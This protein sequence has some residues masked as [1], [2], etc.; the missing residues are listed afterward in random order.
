MDWTGENCT[1]R[2]SLPDLVVLLLS[3]LGLILQPLTPH[4]FKRGLKV[5]HIFESFLVDITLAVGIGKVG[6]RPGYTIFPA[7]LDRPFVLVCY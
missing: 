2:S 6:G 4:L 1:T 3:V 7:F 5:L